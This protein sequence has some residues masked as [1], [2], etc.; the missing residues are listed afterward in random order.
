MCVKN[1]AFIKPS[2]AEQAAA[3]EGA[4]DGDVEL[5][6]ILDTGR[7]EVGR[8][9]SRPSAVLC[10]RPHNNRSVGAG[11]PE[12]CWPSSISRKTY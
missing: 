5:A 1:R 3:E 12:N 9:P 4:E 11:R 7:P 6:D 10:E 2:E 8:N